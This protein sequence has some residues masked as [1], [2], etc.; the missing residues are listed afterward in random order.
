MA[1][2]RLGVLAGDGGRGAVPQVGGGRGGIADGARAHLERGRLKGQHG[3]RPHGDVARCEAASGAQG[4]AQ[5]DG[6]GNGGSVLARDRG[7]TAG[8][9]L[10]H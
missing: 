2:V 3:V 10:V 5:G 6:F 9:H 8:R 4:K 1:D 7:E